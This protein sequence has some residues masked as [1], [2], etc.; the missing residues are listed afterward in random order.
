MLKCKKATVL[1][2]T[3]FLLPINNG[4]VP[5][6]KARVT[7]IANNLKSVYIWLML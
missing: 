3:L 2:L 1:P 7:T 5:Q 4:V 6:M